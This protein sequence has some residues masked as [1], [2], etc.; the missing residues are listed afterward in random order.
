MYARFQH[1]L[2]FPEL[3]ALLCPATPEREL[4]C[5]LENVYQWMY[6]NL[7][8]IE[9]T[10]NISR[11]HGWASLPE[12]IELRYA[13]DDPRLLAH[14]HPGPTYVT[15]YGHGRNPGPDLD[16]DGIALYI[17]DCVG[18]SVDILPGL[19]NVDAADPEPIRTVVPRTQT[20]G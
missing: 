20:G 8:Q 2:T 10:L 18:V 12:D 3:G 13:A 9:V 17:A 6:V 1:D 5:D 19:L 11:D 16:W 14:V 4:N 7:P 15:S